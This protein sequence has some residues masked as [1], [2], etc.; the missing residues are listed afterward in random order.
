[1]STWLPKD[2]R[3]LLAGYY[4]NMSDVGQEKAYDLDDLSPLLTFR[5]H[6]S[7]IP[8][9]GDPEPTS[10]EPDDP[11]SVKDAIHLSIQA[12][13]R[14]KKANALLAAR[15]LITYQPHVHAPNVVVIGLTL[16]GYDLG[17]RYSSILESSGLWFREYREH[18]MW[19]VIAFF[20][21]AVS[22]K[23]IEF[24]ASVLKR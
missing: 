22:T 2:E 1:M 11:E 13:N 16:E 8:E 6:R 10:A 19:L 5:G 4:V 23:L 12:Q 18:W 21:G 3:R 17:R 9:Y 24:L 7:R 20:G 15:R 14:V